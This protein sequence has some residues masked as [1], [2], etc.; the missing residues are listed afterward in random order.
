MNIDIDIN[1]KNNSSAINKNKKG[2]RATTDV[3]FVGDT[4]VLVGQFD[5]S[6]M[7]SLVQRS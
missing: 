5:R 7:L 2:T 4:V 6:V 3:I 1:S